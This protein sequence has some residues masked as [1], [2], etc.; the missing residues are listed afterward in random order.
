MHALAPMRPAAL[1]LLA[2]ATVGCAPI[3]ATR[4]DFTAPETPEGRMC[5]HHCEISEVQCRQ[6]ETLE[7]QNCEAL[8]HLEALAYDECMAKDRSTKW[9]RRHCDAP[10]MCWSPWFESCETAHRQCYQSCGGLVTARQE[11][12]YFC[13]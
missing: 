12:V 11:C 8:R 1:V 2:M 9:K 10:R 7:H 5:A 3:Y 4:Y 6:I 13:D